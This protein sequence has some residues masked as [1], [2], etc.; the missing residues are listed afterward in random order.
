MSQNTKAKDVI[1]VWAFRNEKFTRTQQWAYML[2]LH[3]RLILHNSI[4][5]SLSVR[6]FYQT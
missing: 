2:F 1:K 4:I 5:L 3:R 6:V